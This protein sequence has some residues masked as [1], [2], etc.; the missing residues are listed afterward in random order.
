MENSKIQVSRDKS[1]INGQKDFEILINNE[2]KMFVANGGSN[3]K[4][5]EPGIYNVQ[6]KVDVKRS[7]VKQVE[8]KPGET[9]NLAV[10]NAMTFYYLDMIKFLVVFIM[11]MWVAFG[12]LDDMYVFI[13]LGLSGIDIIL[14][15]TIFRTKYIDIKQE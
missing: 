14:R 6:A 7:A 5:I 13:V 3:S 9:L 10:S 2:S 11:A 4:S 12:G 15:H 8:I 1:I